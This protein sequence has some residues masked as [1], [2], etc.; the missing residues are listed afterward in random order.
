MYNAD[1]PETHEVIADM[2]SVLDRYEDRVL[3]GEIYLPIERLVAYYGKDLGGAHLPFNFQLIHT[4]WTASAVA[5]L[6][7]EYEAALPHGGWPNWV[8]GNHDQPRIAA[9]V[10]A[11]QARIAAMLLLTL[12]GTPTMYYGDELGIGRV[13]IRPDATQDPWEKREGGLG[14]NCDPSRTPFPWDST[15]NAGFSRGRPWLPLNLDYEKCNVEVAERGP[16]FPALSLPPTTSYP[17]PL[18]GIE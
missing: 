11:A 5:K 13:S 16:I 1:Q 8:L 7:R 15:S 14:L 2:R 18:S 17:A 6:I 9:R 3:I 10:G 4:A 12:R